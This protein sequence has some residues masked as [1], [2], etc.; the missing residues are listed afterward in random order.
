L[1]PILQQQGDE[2]LHYKNETGI[3]DNFEGDAISI[4]RREERT[5]LPAGNAIIFEIN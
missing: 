2:S 5:M 3:R 1:T 4:P